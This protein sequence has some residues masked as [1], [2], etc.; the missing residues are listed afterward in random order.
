MASD[1]HKDE[2]KATDAEGP[3]ASEGS[4]EQGAERTVPR[5]EPPS[6]GDRAQAAA[7]YAKAAAGDARAAADEAKAADR[8][9]EELA[10]EARYEAA[11]AGDARSRDEAEAAADEAAKAHEEAEKARR[12]ARAAAGDA[13]LASDAARHGD[14]ETAERAAE[15]ADRAAGLAEA[16]AHDAVV[17]AATA[18]RHELRADLASMRPQSVQASEA[19]L[20]TRPALL[21]AEFDTTAAVLHAAEEVRDAGYDRWDVHSPFPVHGM[22]RAMGL[23]QSHL[24]WIVFAMGWLGFLGAFAM[25]YWMNGIDYPLIIGGKPPESIPSMVPILFECTV[26]FAGVAAV[27]AMLGLNR[28]PRHHHPVFWSERFERCSDDRFFISVEAE[29]PKFDLVATRSLLESLSPTHVELVEEE[30]RP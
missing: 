24:G 4:E 15:L 3:D 14:V 21:L 17:H 30:E 23:G 22:D 28:L 5:S 6:P 1:D 12:M 2:P 16:E 19:P 27:V 13:K 26:L 8:I 25:M 7:D 10:V 18:R 11:I 29:D 20:R 9:A